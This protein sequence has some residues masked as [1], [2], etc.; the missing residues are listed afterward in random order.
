MRAVLSRTRLSGGL[1]GPAA[2]S[3]PARLQLT[4]LVDMMVILVVFLLK[5]FSVE[6]QL[7]TPAVGLELPT[8]SSRTAL[9]TGLV[10]EV[11]PAMV[12][13]DGR[14]IMPTKELTEAEVGDETRLTVALAA[15]APGTASGPVLVQSDHRIDYRHL[16]RVLGACS[17]AGWSDV[18]LVVLKEE[19]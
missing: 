16:S 18:T 14:D 4:S 11:G 10:V 15:A 1:Y 7:V 3:S 17:Q 12:R 8:S 19:S 9:R 2:A 13:V 5:S 6:G